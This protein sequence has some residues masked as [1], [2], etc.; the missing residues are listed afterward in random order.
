M[1]VSLIHELIS[2]CVN[3]IAV[4]AHAV[5]LLTVQST[6]HRHSIEFATAKCSFFNN[7]KESQWPIII[8]WFRIRSLYMYI[9][10]SPTISN[11][12]SHLLVSA[13]FSRA[14][15][16]CNITYGSLSIS[17][18]CKALYCSYA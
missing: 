9:A 1:I 2:S 4:R 14:T 10:F 7:K 15:I 12:R 5:E 11:I 3:S 8:N 6:K 16:A 13:N 18:K 17:Y